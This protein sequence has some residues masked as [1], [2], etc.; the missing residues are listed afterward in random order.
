MRILVAVDENPYSAYAVDE[1]ARL[2]R[3][4]LANV[5]LLGVVPRKNAKA[6][7]SGVAPTQWN[8]E[9]PL[10]VALRAYRETFL[11]RFDEE[12]S[13]YAAKEFAYELVEVRRGIWEELCVC[14]GTRKSLKARLRM[15]NPAKEILAE[16]QEEESDL[17]VLGCSEDNL[18]AWGDGA[19]VPQKI[20][21]DAACSVLVAKE[22]KKGGKVLCCLDQDKVSQQSLEMINQMVTL[23]GAGL[24]IVGITE[25]EDLRTEVERKMDGILKYYIAREIHPW[26]KLVDLPSLHSFISQEAE[27]SLLALWMGKK[28]IL[29]KVFPRGRLNKLVAA[30]KS[31]VLL[32][33]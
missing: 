16:S 8:L 10:A 14:R 24:D 4:T 12:D 1:V 27:R 11:S 2:A 33:R 18:C 20:V 3:N 23:H 31:S 17:I 5:T 7:R 21:N 26:I 29:E 32:L 22:A 28:S 19:K 9:H 25:G 30:S 6:D 15:G 13:P